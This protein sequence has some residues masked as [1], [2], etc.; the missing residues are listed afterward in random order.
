MRPF[1]SKLVLRKWAVLYKRTRKSAK[2]LGIRTLAGAIVGR[3]E[4]SVVMPNL[5]HPMVI[6]PRTTDRFVFEQIFLDRDSELPFD[7]SPRLIV[8]AGANVGFA[9][10]YFADRYPGT[11]IIALEPEPVNFGLLV[12]NTR[13]YPEI[14][15][16]QA[17]L[18]S[19]C[20][21]LSLN[22]QCESWSC[23]VEELHEN[24][25]DAVPGITMVELL[26]RHGHSSI[27][28]LKMDIEGA[29]REV[30]SAQDRSWLSITKVLIVELHDRLR[31]GCSRALNNA[32]SGLGFRRIE[33][34]ENTILINH[35]K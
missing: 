30:F 10:I 13:E 16:V 5:R 34:G 2:G 14:V 21:L 35:D 7:L 29:E 4:I 8:D 31:P 1:V 26:K 24:G 15:Q 19:A 33:R 25:A 3:R 11:T 18:W 28:I 32:I 27:D 6:R 22:R 17:A 9:S 23:R 12:R 20:E